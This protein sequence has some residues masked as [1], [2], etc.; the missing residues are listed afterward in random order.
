MNETLNALASIAG[1]GVVNILTS[2][3]SVAYALG[4][5]TGL[6]TSPSHFTVTWKT[7]GSK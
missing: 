2:I 4:A 1:V 5:I 3:L 6:A 7:F